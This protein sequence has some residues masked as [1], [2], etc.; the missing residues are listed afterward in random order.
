MDS[1]FAIV[2][3]QAQYASQTDKQL[4]KL[5]S[6]ALEDSLGVETMQLVSDFARKKQVQIVFEEEMSL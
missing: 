1:V 3:T 2:D 4:T 5:I 6:M